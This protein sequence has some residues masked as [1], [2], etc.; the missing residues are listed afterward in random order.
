MPCKFMING[1]EYRA[2]HDDVRSVDTK[3]RMTL[4]GHEVSLTVQVEDSDDAVDMHIL[5]GAVGTYW[6]YDSES[7]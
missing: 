3:I 2:L 4:Q 6:V 5:P 1:G 7:R